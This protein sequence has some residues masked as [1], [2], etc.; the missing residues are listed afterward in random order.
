[1]ASPA[2][3]AS[4]SASAAR[5]TQHRPRSGAGR[6]GERSRPPGPGAAA[7]SAT[8]SHRSGCEHLGHLRGEGRG[9]ATTTSA[10][11][12]SATTS[13]SARTTTRS[14]RS[15]TNSTSWVDTTTA[16]PRRPAP[17]TIGQRRLRRGSRGLGW[18]R[19]AAPPRARRSADG[20]HR[21][22]PLPLGEVARVLRR[23]RCRAR[24][25]SSRSAAG[26][27]R[28]G[29]ALEVGLG[30]LLV[31]GGQ[32][33]QVGG[34][35]GTRPTRAR[36]RR[37]TAGGVDAGDVTVP[38]SR[39]PLPCSAHSS[40][41]L[42]EPLRPMRAMTSPRAHVQVDVA[43]R[44]H[45]AVADH[46]A[47]GARST[48]AA[49]PRRVTVRGSRVGRAAASRSRSAA[50]DGGR[51]A[52]TAA[53][54]DHPAR[55]PSSTTGGA[56]AARQPSGWGRPGDGAVGAGPHDPVGVLQDPLQAVLG[57]RAR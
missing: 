7:T 24:C 20:Q 51:R 48:G 5:A 35:W 46:H 27:G 31:D 38:P 10:V 15:A 42:P 33:E 36:A 53:P 44:H 40:E 11:G 30:A 21:G 29:A 37:G 43:H 54:G 23:R 25:R 19:R 50:A 14:A 45:V 57:H 16:A 41:D 49:A 8:V 28:C 1:M 34:V 26:A 56:T 39:R 9:E 4:T 22:E 52:P 3:D 13:P 32:V 55:R 18:A 6:G 2:S 47:P 12:P 17:S